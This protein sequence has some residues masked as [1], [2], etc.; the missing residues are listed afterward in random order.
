MNRSTLLLV[1]MA[2]ASKYNAVSESI[3]ND[4]LSALLIQC[5][6]RKLSSST[7]RTTVDARH[8]HTMGGL[9]DEGLMSHRTHYRSYRGR[10]STDQMTQPTVSKYWRKEDAKDWASIP[11]GPPQSVT[12]IKH[13]GLHQMDVSTNTARGYYHAE[14]MRTV[15]HCEPLE[16]SWHVD[17]F[18][19][20]SILGSHKV[21]QSAICSAW[22]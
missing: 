13:N 4:L 7:L 1:L 15:P 11:L 5:T 16:Y 2:A 6:P 20:R 19:I 8:G 3:W 10:V 18:C 9:T 17:T 22:R 21:E 12:I 14:Q